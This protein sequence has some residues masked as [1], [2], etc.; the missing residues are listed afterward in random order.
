MLQTPI[1]KWK[2]IGMLEWGH[3]QSNTTDYFMAELE[4]VIVNGLDMY[5][6]YA[7]LEKIVL[8]MEGNYLGT[9]SD[10]T[11]I[12]ANVRNIKLQGS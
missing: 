10:G 8:A 2:Y 9:A 11:A 1:S 4:L 12:P 3:N 6:I 7:K 5:P